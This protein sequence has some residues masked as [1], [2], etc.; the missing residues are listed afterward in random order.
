MTEIMIPIG[1]VSGMGLIAGVILSLA[2]IIFHKPG[3]EKEETLREALPGINCGACGFSGCDGYAKAMAEGNAGPTNC[4]P[5]GAETRQTLSEILG[6][7]VGEMQKVAAYV[8]CNGN[9]EV[10]HKKM[11]YAGT[12]TCYGANQIFGGPQACHFGCM[13]FGD[14]EAVCE[15][16]AIH[17]VDGVAKVDP[18][19]CVGC[20]KCIS[21]CPKNLIKM[22]PAE[23]TSIVACSNQ[24]K[25]GGVR[26]ICSVG[27]ISCNRCVKTCP[28]KAITMENNV[29]VIDPEL[30]INCG[31][32]VEAC[33]QECIEEMP[34]KVLVKNG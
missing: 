33:P 27:C 6:V 13:G 18:D 26:K 15:Y 21:A 20:L 19:K 14:C 8:R 9:C 10:T 29:A 23:N 30:C 28:Q 34:A 3:D 4:T 11:D 1:I 12:S 32:C 7:E 2:T 5:G 25:G 24:E 22:L 31:E 17:V 16:D